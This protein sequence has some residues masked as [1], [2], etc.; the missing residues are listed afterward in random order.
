MTRIVGLAVVALMALPAG[1]SGATTSVRAGTGAPAPTG[2]TSGPSTGPVTGVLTGHTMNGQPIPCAARPDGV[3]VCHGDAN[4]SAADLRLETFD[5]TPLSLYVTLPPA[6][7]S[8]VD[9]GY[10]LMV[11]S[12][13]WGAPPSGPDDPQYGGPT[14]AQWASDGYAVVQL[15]ARGWGTSCGTPASR[16]VNPAA[17]A[18]GYV[19]LDDLRYEARDVQNVAGLLVDEGIADPN[20]IGVT[21]ESYGAG[22]SLELATLDNRVMNVDGSL[23]PWTSPAGTRLHIAAAAP[24]AGWSDLVYALMPNGRTLDSRVTPVTADLA[25]VGV[26]KL[27]ISSGLY[28]VGAALAYYAP[29]GSDPEADLTTWFATMNAGEPYDTPKVAAI[30]EQLARFHSPYYL[31]AGAYGTRAQAPAPLLMATGFTDDIFPVDE[32]LRYYNLARRMHPGRPIA[33][34]FADIGHQ[35]AQNKPADGA[36]LVAT[37]KAFLDHHVKGTGPRPVTG[38]TALTQ[39]CPS[40]APSGGPYRAFTWEALR[41][42]EVRYSSAR[43][44]T[45]L[46]TAGDPAVAARFDPVFG[47]LACTT[48]P[49]TDQGAGVATYRLPTASGSGYTLLGGATVTAD[50]N[51][52]GQYAYVA[53]RLLDVDPATNTETLVA[54]GDYRIDPN[55]PNGRQSF[56]LHPGAWHF[57]AGHVPKLELLGQDSPYLRPSNGTF[58]ITVSNL[59][60]R[61][62]VHELLFRRYCDTG[63]GVPGGSRP[64]AAPSWRGRPDWVCPPWAP[65]TR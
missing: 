65:W 30:L 6:P 9:G 24:F 46:S 32:S 54:R 7:A 48:A 59:Q 27:S 8:G 34:L 64:G 40:T 2:P 19:R 11:Q 41:P 39:T 57:A 31:L 20:R 45:I 56:Q 18:K 44:Q 60:L 3:R 12:H 21:G 50:L 15:T 43:A 55:A 53:A 61:L 13:G 10:P 16:A 47:G 28:G 23:G 37:V 17:C 62:P 25:P 29:A 5:G 1:V 49:A 26:S 36:L 33:L 58:S 4:G 38:V 51:V 14:A 22:V 63:S 35:R 52:T 42:G